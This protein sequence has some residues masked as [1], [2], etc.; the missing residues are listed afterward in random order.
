M[1]RK[2][3]DREYKQMKSHRVIL[4]ANLDMQLI[5]PGMSINE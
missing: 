3:F 4:I 2:R 5:S 1:K